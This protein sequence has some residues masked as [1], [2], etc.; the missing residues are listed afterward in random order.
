MR[1]HDLK[2]AFLP[3]SPE[4]LCIAD[5]SQNPTAAYKIRGALASAQTAKAAG[6]D[7]LVTASAG[8]HGAGIAFASQLLGMQARVYV[9]ENAPMVKIQKIQGF[10]AEVVKVGSCFDDCLAAARLDHDVSSSRGKFVHPF[11]DVMVAAGQGT[12]GVELLEHAAQLVSAS[13]YD[14]VRVYLPIGGGGLM[15]GV[16]SALK[17][18]WP[19]SFPPLEIVGVIDE[20]AP[21]SLLATLFGRPVK[22]SPNTIADGTKVALVGQTFLSVSHLI[23]HL[24]LVP[25]D[26]IVSA[27]RQYERHTLSRIEGA[28]ALALAGAETVRTNALLGTGTRVLSF[29]LVSGRNVDAQTYHETI[30]ATPRL[31]LVSHL[32]QGFDVVIPEEQGQLVHFLQTVADYNIASLTYK[33]RSG[34]VSGLLRVEF[35]VEASAVA[36]LERIL[37]HRFPGSRRLKPGEQMVYDVGSPVAKEYR[38]ELITL[39]DRPGSFLQCIEKLSENE[40]L[41]SVGFLFY[42]KPPVAGTCAQVVIGRR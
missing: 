11:D 32:R 8:N 28:G 25:H 12:I 22:V 13:Y 5:A 7:L 41:G 31:N 10:G 24:L 20:S 30:T 27:M 40:P 6:S 38:E 3:V 14:A 26:S 35:E 17:T 4:G 16:S 9:P 34:A 29:A 1:A 21:A 33:Q 2:V 18:R 39:S 15:A 37:V 19:A 36:P 42:R 23:D